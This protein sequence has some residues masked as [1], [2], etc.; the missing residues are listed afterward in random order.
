M[1]R[2]GWEGQMLV[3]DVGDFDHQRP[4]THLFG[5]DAARLNGGKAD[6]HVVLMVERFIFMV[7]NWSRRRPL[8]QCSKVTVK[9]CHSARVFPQ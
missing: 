4:H 8:W 7:E 9:L 5:A 1:K 3:T 6:D 2:D